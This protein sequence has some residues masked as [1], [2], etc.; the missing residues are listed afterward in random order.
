METTATGE[1]FRAWRDGGGD[2]AWG[3]L[4][5]RVRPRMVLWASTQV[6]GALRGRVEPEDLAHEILAALHASRDEF[7]GQYVEQLLGWAF[8]VARHRAADLAKHFAA[9]KR[10]ERPPPPTGTPT[11]PSGAAARVERRTS[12]LRATS[13]ALSRLS[14]DD[15]AVVRLAV[16][17]ALP[18]ERVAEA[19]GITVG[20]AR[21]RKF[22]ALEALK[23]AFGPELPRLAALLETGPG[24]APRTTGEARA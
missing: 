2:V 15:R 14:D 23:R 11:S 1:R 10:V 7:R 13:D 9:V 16:L 5:E 22:R 24:R 20:A 19:L 21:V 3:A 18:Y 4:L 8:S 17:E 6:S 12:L